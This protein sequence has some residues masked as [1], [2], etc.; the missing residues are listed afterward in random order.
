MMGVHVGSKASIEANQA[1]S[2]IVSFIQPPQKY[3]RNRKISMEEL[4]KDWHGEK[5]GEERGG[6]DVGAEVVE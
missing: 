6:S 3:H 5:V 2:Q 1:K 4:C